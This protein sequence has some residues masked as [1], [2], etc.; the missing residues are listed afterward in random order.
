VNR[1][2]VRL[3]VAELVL[4]AGGAIAISGQAGPFR[5]PLWPLVAVAAAFAVLAVLPPL[6]VEL[7]RNAYS[8]V[9]TEPLI[10]VA[11]FLLH[12]LAVVAAGMIGEVAMAVAHRQPALKSCFNF[13]LTSAGTVA[14]V[15]TFSLIGAPDPLD[16][17]AWLAV[18]LTLGAL[19]VLNTASMAAV[20]AISEQAPVTR[21]ALRLL[22]TATANY[23]ASS[24]VGI[25]A[26]VLLSRTPFGPVLLVPVLGLLVLATRGIEVQRAERDRFERLYTASSELTD[27]LD[28][29]ATIAAVG[30]QARQLVTGAAAICCT[31]DDDGGWSGTIVDDAG[32]RALLPPV[33][34]CIRRLA[35]EHDSGELPIHQVDASFRGLVAGADHVVWAERRGEPSLVLAV[36]RDVADDGQGGHR[37]DILSAFVQ[38]AAH[39]VANALLH[40]AVREALRRQIDLNRQKSEFVA[41]V[42]HELRTPLTGVLGSI[43]TIRRLGE[44][45]SAEEQQR[46]LELGFEQGHRLRRLI[47]DLLVAASGEQGGM[48]LDVGP[49][50]LR[51]LLPS[52]ADELAPLGAG[53]LRV[54]VDEDVEAVSTDEE[55]LR[56]IV[57]NLVENAVKYAPDGP[58]DLTGTLVDGNV[59]IAVRDRGPGIPATD[60]ERVF[61]RFVQLDQSST[62]RQGGTGLGLYLSRQLAVLLGGALAA[63]DPDGPGAELVL[64]LPVTV[65]S[66]SAP[67]AAPAPASRPARVMTRPPAHLLQRPEPQLTS[68]ST[69]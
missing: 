55:K 53:R 33:V 7:R 34:E 41:A 6:H 24:S 59:T 1:R 51:R 22:P 37:A 9:L 49:V 12:P 57:V 15:L 8:L 56:R 58:I 26:V 66:P 28:L 18:V 39:V 45:L 69:R 17:M 19:T 14:A 65:A 10:A 4:A 40:E 11:L 61:E 44:R 36:V 23:L 35:S 62:R 38:Q 3:I 60:R 20:L 54:H 16:P 29:G 48:R 68:G 27:L 43:Q 67:D 47:E 5:Q 2:V 52:I 63:R 30:T 32:V 64:D 13:A 50:D 46:M 25:A 42:S 21:V 31:R